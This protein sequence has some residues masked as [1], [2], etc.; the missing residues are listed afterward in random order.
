MTHVRV[1]RSAD[2][3]PIAAHLGGEGPP[4]ILVHGAAA[5]HTTWRTSGPLLARHYTTWAI[6]RRGRAASGDTLP[7]A[8]EREFEDVAAVAEAAAAESGK[9]VPVV[10][11]SFGGRVALGA[12]LRSATVSRLVGYEGAP[13]PP[14]RPYERS[15]LV[16]RLDA[17]RDAGQPDALLE[18][19]LGEVV[20][21]SDDDIEA[22]RANPVWSARVAAAPT[23]V[24]ELQ[25]AAAQA[26][27][28]DELSRVSVPVL[29]VLGSDSRA[30]FHV[31]TAA[32]DARLR[33]GRVVVIDGARHAAH[34]TDAERFVA[35]VEAFISGP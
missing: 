3:T 33:A 2:G 34:H 18:T 11:H 16:G 22:Y 29:Q 12:A 6:D 25:G 35:E 5:D 30:P 28:L 15:D 8:I 27:G 31:A 14:D 26:A 23:I 20:G 9:P 13:A 21:M 17:L 10:G 7:Y 4:V 19:F 32:L 1:V 24:R